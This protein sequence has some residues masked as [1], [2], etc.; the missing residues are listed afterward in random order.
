MQRMRQK[1]RQ[2][3]PDGVWEGWGRAE[4]PQEEPWPPPGRGSSGQ[5]ACELGAWVGEWERTQKIV[6]FGNIQDECQPAA[7]GELVCQAGSKWAY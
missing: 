7:M 2:K 5:G 4:E 3:L 1:E 6:E